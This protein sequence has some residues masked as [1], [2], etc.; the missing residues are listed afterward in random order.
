MHSSDKFML[1][2]MILGVVSVALVLFFDHYQNESYNE[3]V[4][5]CIKETHDL[6]HCKEMFKK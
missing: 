1:L 2:I 3:N 4:Q 5:Q 6:E